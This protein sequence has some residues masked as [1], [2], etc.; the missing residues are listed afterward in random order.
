MLVA[1][2]VVITA[3]NTAS[4]AAWHALIARG[5]RIVLAEFIDGC[6][7]RLLFPGVGIG[8]DAAAHIARTKSAAS[9]VHR[10]AMSQ[11]PITGLCFG[12]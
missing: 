8:R 3:S 9:S 1:Q 12:W 11:I 10:I 7:M 4:A 2:E 6:S 5:D